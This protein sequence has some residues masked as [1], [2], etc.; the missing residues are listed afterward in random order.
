[1]RFWK[2]LVRFV[3]L[4]AIF[5]FGALD[6]AIKR[7]ATREQRAEWLHQFAGYPLR[8]MGIAW[9]VDGVFP[10]S[11]VIV[12]NH[13]GYLDIV[14][15]ATQHRCVFVS[16]DALARV[17]LLGW[18]ATMAGTVFVAPGSGGSAN[19]AKVPLREA[20]AAGLPIILF[21][22]GT[23]SDGSTVLEFRG[24]ALASLL[25]AG[26]KVTAAYIS[27]SFNQNNGTGISIENDVAFWGDDAHLFRHM[28]GLVSL[29]GIEVNIRIADKPIDFVA[30]F[31]ERKLAAAEAR[32]AVL[33]LRPVPAD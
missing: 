32:A 16:N 30:T 11:G 33:N 17:P 25:E 10:E 4:T 14:V 18:I 31:H 21:P 8:A 9:K 22:E 26:Q 13:I 6:I 23:T 29:R 28:F 12:S 20:A 3:Q 2:S 24:G 5:V 15:L 7:P 19:R 27:Y 1:V